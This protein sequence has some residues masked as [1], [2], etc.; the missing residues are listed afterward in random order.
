[1]NSSHRFK[2]IFKPSQLATIT[3]INP[4]ASL[5]RFIESHYYHLRSVCDLITIYADERGFDFFY[6]RYRINVCRISWVWW[7]NAWITCSR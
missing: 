2:E 4:E 1:M 5:E 6:F 3:L 7:E